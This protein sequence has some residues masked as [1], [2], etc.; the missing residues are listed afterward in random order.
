LDHYSAQVFH[1]EGRKN[2][3]DLNYGKKT[4]TAKDYFKNEGID[5]AG[6]F[7][8][9]KYLDINKCVQSAM[10]AVAKK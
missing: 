2:G 1:L 5:S 4:K 3:T 10:K 9:F 6:R 8:E 7:T